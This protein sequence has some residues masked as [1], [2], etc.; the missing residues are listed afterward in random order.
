MVNNHHISYLVHAFSMANGALNSFN[1][2]TSTPRLYDLTW[3]KNRFEPLQVEKNK[4][5][6]KILFH[7]YYDFVSFIK[8]F[9]LTIYLKPHVFFFSVRK[10]KQICVL[11]TIGFFISHGINGRHCDFNSAHWK[12]EKNIFR[13]GTQICRVTGTIPFF[14]LA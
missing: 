13:V 14:Y 9:V 10:N 6:C 5:H 1:L 11:V 3:Q 2:D 4:F 7:H 8:Q 12:M